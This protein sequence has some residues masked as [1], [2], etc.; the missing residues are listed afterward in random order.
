MDK[1]SCIAAAR[2]AAIK[3][4]ILQNLNGDLSV[5]ALAQRHGISGRYLHKLFE[6][7]G[8][9]LSRHVQG[10]RLEALRRMLVDP[11]NRGRTVADL[12]YAAGFNDIS[13]C[14][15][16]FKARYGTSPGRTRNAS[17]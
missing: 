9:T 7:D 2:L 6:R 17:S 14:N 3:A 11:R 12:V 15:R 16:A 1:M 10:L 13:T 8:A 5:D 4:D